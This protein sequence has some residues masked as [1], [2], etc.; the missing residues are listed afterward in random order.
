[1]MKKIIIALI[2]VLLPIII[3]MIYFKPKNELV[4]T[5][6]DDV[7]PNVLV[8]N[9]DRLQLISEDIVLEQSSNNFEM[10]HWI[11]ALQGRTFICLAE[12]DGSISRTEND[13]I[14]LN[15]RLNEHN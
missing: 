11:V 8:E 4:D 1:M 10:S 5:L 3:Y 13:R 12:E 15:V 9:S 14:E 6:C 7:K 2:L